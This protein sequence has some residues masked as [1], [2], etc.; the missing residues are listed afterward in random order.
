MTWW[1]LA[2]V[3]AS[4]PGICFV[5]YSYYCG[6]L[7]ERRSF[8]GYFDLVKGIY[9]AK[10]EGQREAARFL[11]GSS[12][13]VL[14][15][16]ITLILFLISKD[17]PLVIT[18]NLASVLAGEAAIWFGKRNRIADGVSIAE[19]KHALAH[20]SPKANTRQWKAV[21]CVLAFWGGI[22][23]LAYLGARVWGKLIH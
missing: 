2:M 22:V 21:L 9:K 16:L 23:A 18:V 4:L 10:R 5:C 6:Y 8:R 15:V 17:F 12:A 7:E 19:A 20:L 13:P 11:G 1:A 14:T 3:F